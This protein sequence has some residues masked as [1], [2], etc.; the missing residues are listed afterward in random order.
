MFHVKHLPFI[1]GVYKIKLPILGGLFFA[2]PPIQ[3]EFKNITR[4]GEVA[5]E[6]FGTVGSV[7]SAFVCRF[8]PLITVYNQEICRWA[9][10]GSPNIPWSHDQSQIE[11][12]QVQFI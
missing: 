6:K 2:F 1:S 7:A 5:E 3:I 4:K 10:D 8:P 11:K 12:S 9:A